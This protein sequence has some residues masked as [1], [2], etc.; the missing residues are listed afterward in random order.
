MTLSV[1]QIRVLEEI[2]RE[3]Q[4]ALYDIEDKYYYQAERTL[5]SLLRLLEQPAPP[6]E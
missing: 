6:I 4:S 2:K 3:V 5:R 1:E